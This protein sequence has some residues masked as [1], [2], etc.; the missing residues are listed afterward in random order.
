MTYTQPLIL[1]CLGVILAVLIRAGRSYK[2][3]ALVTSGALGMLAL[4]LPA[5][6]W[7]VSRPLEAPYPV[8]PFHLPSRLQAIV[9]LGSAVQPPHFE[10][11]Y[12]L[13]DADTFDRCEYAAWIWRQYGPIPV[14][15][16]EGRQEDRASAM[17]ELLRRAGVS[18]NLI[19]IESEST[20]THQNAKNGARILRQHGITRIA[21]V[22]DAQSMLR[23]AAC[24]RK[25][26]V[27]VTPAPSGFRSFGS[28]GQ[29]LLPSWKAIR[30]NELSLHEFLGLTWYRLRGWI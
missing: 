20:S 26:G 21:L 4:S 15:A 5:A 19:W 30:R 27:D 1:L 16:C 14:L 22:V 8:R 6:D 28:L 18:E 24:F 25:E 12:P 7:L 11:P 23:A 13:P 10:R 9:V 29:E 2:G 17:G 3:K